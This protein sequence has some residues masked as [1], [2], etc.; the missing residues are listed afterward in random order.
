MR[1]SDMKHDDAHQVQPATKLNQSNKYHPEKVM[2]WEYSIDSVPL[3]RPAQT[4]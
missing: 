2:R 1:L 4:A 3:H